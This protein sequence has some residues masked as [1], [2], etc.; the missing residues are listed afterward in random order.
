[1]E[2]LP[3]Y[4]EAQFGQDYE[5]VEQKRGWALIG[6]IPENEN[7][8]NGMAG[9]QEWNRPIA[10]EGYILHGSDG[11]IRNIPAWETSA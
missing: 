4:A 7:V 5:S 9:L 10:L 11:G 2:H 8:L 6:I 1:M 3:L